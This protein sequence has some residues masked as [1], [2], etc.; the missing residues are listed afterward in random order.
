MYRQVRL[1]VNSCIFL[2]L[3]LQ[4][5]LGVLVCLRLLDS[6]STSELLVMYNVSRHIYVPGV[7]KFLF[8]LASTYV[9]CF[10]ELKES[11]FVPPRE[12]KLFAALSMKYCSCLLYTSDAAD[13]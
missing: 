7:V 4:T 13:E 8:D 12:S 9:V 3:P 6:L 11:K 2:G 10:L 1:E 5:K